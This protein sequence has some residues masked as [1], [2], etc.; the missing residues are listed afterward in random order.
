LTLTEKAA[1]TTATITAPTTDPRI[2]RVVID[3]TTGTV[4]V[5]TGTEAA[6][7][8]PPALT[9]GKLPI[10]QV[11]LVVSQTT[12]VN[13]DITDERAW[14]LQTSAEFA[15]GD[16]LLFQQTTAPTGYTKETNSAFNDVALRIVTG[17][18]GSD[19]ADAFSTV[20]GSAVKTG[21]RTLT[22]AQLASHSGH[23]T[24]APT[25]QFSTS[26]SGT[27]AVTSVSTT[28]KGSDSSHDHTMTMDMKYRDVIIAQKD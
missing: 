10:A 25:N 18:A 19:G 9:A 8:T 20:F 27:N 23:V 3:D 13:A 24:N 21:G 5:I 11:A 26:M 4:S 22:Q 28:N 12:I 6:S 17:T 16:R 15:S 2:D 14:P 7:P 1:Q